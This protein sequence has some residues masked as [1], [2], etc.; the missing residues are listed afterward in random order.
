MLEQPLDFGDVTFA[1]H[2]GGARNGQ[3]VR[4]RVERAQRRKFARQPC[5]FNL[6][7]VLG[8][9]EILQSLLS[10]INEHRAGGQIA[11]REFTGSA[12]EQDLAAVTDSHEPR[13]A[14]DRRSEIV[15]VALVG[16]AAMQRH[17]HRHTADGAPVR[18]RECPLRISSSCDSV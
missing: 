12:G 10:E 3:V 9:G 4:Q 7:Y 14:V 1:S 15:T 2:E 5:D 6:P 13:D 18:A 17:A 8:F 11:M 16:C